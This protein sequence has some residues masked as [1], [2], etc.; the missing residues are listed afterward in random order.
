MPDQHLEIREL[1]LLE[2]LAEKPEVRQLELAARVGIAVGTVNWL[3]KRLASK[4]YLKVKRIGQ[5]R[6]Q[7]LLTPAGFAA[8]ARLTERYLRDSMQLYRQVREEARGQLNL[9]RKRGYTAVRLGGDPESDLLDVCRLT[10]LEQGI[11]VVRTGVPSSEDGV[12]T[13]RAVGKKLLLN[14]PK[15]EDDA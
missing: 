10:C 15:E 8:K 14:W 3:L 12:P 13:L 7:Y 4:G 1:K 9:L 2:E 6:W 5:W 11:A